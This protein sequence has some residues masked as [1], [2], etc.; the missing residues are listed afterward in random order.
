MPEITMARRTIDGEIAYC[1]MQSD[2]SR[3]FLDAVSGKASPD[4]RRHGI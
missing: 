1:D 2:Q 4:R 3:P